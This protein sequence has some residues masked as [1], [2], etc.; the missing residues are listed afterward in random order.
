VIQKSP[1]RN[2]GWPAGKR[3]AHPGLMEQPLNRLP[4]GLDPP[5]THPG[6]ANVQ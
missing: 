4:D 6:A 2:C 3:E 5:V 1:D